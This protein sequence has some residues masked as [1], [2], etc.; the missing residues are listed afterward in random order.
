[1]AIA[2]YESLPDSDG[3]PEPV[4]DGPSAIQT[5]R[6]VPQTIAEVSA[7]WVA[8][9]ERRAAAGAALADEVMRP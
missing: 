9:I 4:T 2:F 8:Q 5:V 6:I 7:E 3:I 1:M